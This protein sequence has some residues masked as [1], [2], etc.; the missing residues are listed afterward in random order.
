LALVY[1]SYIILLRVEAF[2]KIR[3]QNNGSAE[4]AFTKAKEDVQQ[5]PYSWFTES[6]DDAYSKSRASIKGQIVL[7]DGRPA[8]GAAIFWGDNQSTKTPL[9]QGEG[10]YYRTYAKEDGSFEILNMR[11]LKPSSSEKALGSIQAWPNGGNISDVTTVLYLNDVELKRGITDLGLITWKIQRHR[12]PKVWQ[13]GEIDRTAK[14]FAFSGPPHEHARSTKC[15]ANLT[16]VIGINQTSDWCFAQ[17]HPGTWNI[18]F[19]LPDP[20]MLSTPATLSIALAAYTSGVTSM[21]IINGQRIADLNSTTVG[22][23]DPSLYRSGTLAGE[24]HL[25]QIPLHPGLLREGQNVIALRIK[26]KG[27]TPG[28]SSSDAKIGEVM[29]WRGLMFDSILLEWDY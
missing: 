23:G 8:S 21:V 15:P 25:V 3:F 19:F 22:A 5:W 29:H 9:D 1:S 12:S 28:W 13:I 16:Y 24:W 11:V 2:A 18:Q 6:G 4:D 27:F 17:V 14:G 10:Y 26:G 20:T 7:S